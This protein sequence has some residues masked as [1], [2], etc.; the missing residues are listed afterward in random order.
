MCEIII[1]A[2]AFFSHDRKLLVFPLSLG[3]SKSLLAFRT[4][5]NIQA[6]LNSAVV[7]TVSIRPL[8]SNSSSLFTNP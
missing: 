5:L 6:D 3:T 1:L 2:S 8:I 7:W 4:L